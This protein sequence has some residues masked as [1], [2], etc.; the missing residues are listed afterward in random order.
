LVLAV[1]SIVLSGLLGVSQVGLGQAARPR[2]LADREPPGGAA[3]EAPRWVDEARLFG[4]DQMQF[5]NFARDVALD[6]A[7]A[8]VGANLADIGGTTDRGAAYVFIRD[9]ETWTE[10]AQLLA[11]DGAAGDSFG[12]SV[13]LHGDTAVVG[14]PLADIG[15]EA[16]EGAVYVFERLAGSW[17]QAQKLVASDGDELD[18]LGESVAL[19]G[20]TLI[21]GAI[22]EEG[23]VGEGRE[24][25]QGSG[26][27]Y[28]FVRQGGLWVE[29]AKLFDPNGQCSEL[30]GNDVAL[31]ADTALIGA[32]N[33]SSEGVPGQ[34]AAYVYTRIGGIWGLEQR[35]LASDGDT[36]DLFGRSVALDRDTALIGAE[37]KDIGGNIR[38][39]AAYVFRRSGTS[40]TEEQRL[41]ASDGHAEASFGIGAALMGNLALVGAEFNFPGD[42]ER[43]VV[44][45]YRYQGGAWVEIQKFAA[46][47]GNNFDAFGQAISLTSDR[48][49]ISHRNEVVLPPPGGSAWI[50]RRPTL[51]E[52][53][54]ESGDTSAWDQVVAGAAAQ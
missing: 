53:G 39:G 35:L 6:G 30:F 38:Q 20:D 24:G 13:A 52:D 21:A 15:G 10:Q 12:Y 28:V 1:L 3:L 45:E 29:Q 34:G 43:G 41:T 51:F 18:N 11:S 44:Y 48:V 5:W 27:A 8:L 23:A 40:W 19:G 14:A 2:Q 22:S 17:T 47:Q 4:S 16:G 32:Y 50:F 49:L 26:A 42:P 36:S 7:T 25:C 33:F 37:Q 31:E 54:F 46:P 9:G